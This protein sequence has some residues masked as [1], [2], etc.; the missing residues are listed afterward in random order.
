MNTGSISRFVASALLALGTLLA[1][2]NWSLQPERAAAWTAALVTLGAMAIGLAFTSRLSPNT[3]MRQG[4]REITSG[5]IFAGL[6]LV[7]ALASKLAANLGAPSDG[8]LLQRLSMA[9]MGVFFVVMG[10]AFPKMLTPLASLQCN[11]AKVQA[12]QRF[13][14]WVWVLSGL[15]YALAW[16][17]LPID[18]ANPVSMALMLAGVLTVAMRTVQMK[19]RSSAG[20]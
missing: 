12:F 2:W 20:V 17:V 9:M 19:W 6:I 3:K 16:L 11:P 14:G 1:A 10:N 4:S 7:F 18:L 15:G 8:E 13:V 5:V